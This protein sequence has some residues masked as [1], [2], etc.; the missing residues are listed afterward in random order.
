MCTI[1]ELEGLRM[2]LLKKLGDLLKIETELYLGSKGLLDT[3]IFD[4]YRQAKYNHLQAQ[5]RYDECFSKLLNDGSF[6]NNR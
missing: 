4:N 1:K 3:V 6:N 5:N 2:D